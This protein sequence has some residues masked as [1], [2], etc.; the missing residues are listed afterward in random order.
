MKIALLNT[1]PT[2]RARYLLD[3]FRLGLQQHGDEGIW[4]NDA[5]DLHR[6][7]TVDVGVQVCMPNRN[8]DGDPLDHFRLDAWAAMVKRNRR[9]LVLDTGFVKNQYDLARQMKT[10]P[11]FHVDEPKTYSTVDKLIHY[12]LAFDGIKG[13]GDHCIT[14][15]TPPDRWNRLLK[16]IRPW[17]KQ[18]NYILVMTQPRHGQSSQDTDVLSWY[19]SIL[20]K[21][22]ALSR[23]PL[24]AR[25][26]PRISKQEK[27]SN[28]Y[29][30]MMREICPGVRWST[31]AALEDDLRRARLSV[32]YSSSAGVTSV[33]EGVPVLVGSPA[34]MAWPVAEKSVELAVRKPTQ[35][36]RTEW[37]K[38]LAY[39]QWNAHE[40]RSG[41]AWAHYRAHALL[42]RK[43]S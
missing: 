23:A 9:V 13:F 2:P 26:H 24:V 12:E 8:H 28:K 5:K 6:L 11:R 32:V 3:C 34:C 33:L 40:M 38:S 15:N 21:I 39:S 27:H 22:S 35:Y 20:K 37:A 10:R 16:Q 1:K 36:D 18:G 31:N 17:R 29:K 14:P 7:D 30:A 25:L 41:V 19:A 4:V 42:P 43:R